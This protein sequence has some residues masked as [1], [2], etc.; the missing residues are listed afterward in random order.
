MKIN[1]ITNYLNDDS[2]NYRGRSLSLPRDSKGH[3]V[4]PGLEPSPFGPDD[5]VGGAV[6][7]IARKLAGSQLGK[8]VQ[9]ATRQAP[10]IG[11]TIGTKLQRNIPLERHEIRLLKDIIDKQAERTTQIIAAQ[12]LSNFINNRSNDE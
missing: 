3:P 8:I 9:Q 7:A 5:L 2:S 4:E 6:G 12:E 11:S 1:E 10:E